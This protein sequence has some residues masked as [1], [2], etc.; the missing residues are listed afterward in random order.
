MAVNGEKSKDGRYIGALVAV[1]VCIQIPILA[2][3]LTLLGYFWLSSL[4]APASVTTLLALLGGL[5]L[6]IIVWLLLA[7]H[8]SHRGYKL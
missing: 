7:L 8:A 2:A 3:F 4:P 6:T 1:G 5:I